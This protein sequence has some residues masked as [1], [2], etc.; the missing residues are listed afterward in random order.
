MSLENEFWQGL[1]E[2]AGH[3]HA[4]IVLLVEQIDR[5]LAPAT[6]RPPYEYSFSSIS[7]TIS[8]QRRE[9]RCA[10]VH[11]TVMRNAPKLVA[12]LTLF[13]LVLLLLS[14]FFGSAILADWTIDAAQVCLWLAEA[15]RPSFCGQIAV[16]PTLHR[17]SRSTQDSRMKLSS[18]CH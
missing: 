17:L 3:N 8:L 16:V 7:V 1:H 14:A 18:S 15:L 2:I 13:A 9:P 10:S 12:V 6:S 5:A 4:K 11:Y